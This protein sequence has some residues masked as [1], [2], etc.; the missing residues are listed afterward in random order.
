MQLLHWVEQEKLEDPK[1]Y[2]AQPVVGGSAVSILTAHKSKGLEFSVVIC[3]Y[4][5]FAKDDKLRHLESFYQEGEEEITIPLTM[6]VLEQFKEELNKESLQEDLRVLYV[7]L[8]RAK[9]QLITFLSPIGQ[10][11]RS[12]LAYLLFF[13]NS[14]F[15]VISEFQKSL[16][17][18]GSEDLK[19]LVVGLCEGSKGLIELKEISENLELSPWEPV[20][21]QTQKFAALELTT[22]LDQSHKITS[23]S[24]LTRNAGHAAKALWEN[25]EEDPET[26]LT[27]PIG[28][29]AEVVLKDFPKGAK[30]GNFFHELFENIEFIIRCF[31]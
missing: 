15:T 29:T 27:F 10:Y 14:P 31:Y 13:D 22:R 24:A 5:G 25:R 7:A 21:S 11:F 23:F 1:A 16:K 6:E 3:P 12:A 18:M 26:L 19:A 30:A 20:K 2:E 8:T 4:L 9:H 17:A 28:E